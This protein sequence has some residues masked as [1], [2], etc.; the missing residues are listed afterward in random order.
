MNTSD[1]G[2]KYDISFNFVRFIKFLKEHNILATAIAAVLSDR[3]NE[4]TNTFVDYLVMPI[5]NRDGDGD[6]TRDI[7]KLED[8]EFM[9]LGVKFRIGKVFMSIVKF[10]IITYIVFIIAKTVKKVGKIE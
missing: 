1:S 6:G 3:I 9:L 5:I 4:L 7:K 2:D 10:I 8:I